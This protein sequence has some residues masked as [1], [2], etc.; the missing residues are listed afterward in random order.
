MLISSL[1]DF[2]SVRWYLNSILP[3]LYFFCFFFCCAGVALEA[4]AATEA[5]V[6]TGGG[7]GAGEVEA[8]EDEVD[9]VL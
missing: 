9:C 1:F 3:S 6:G 2:L 4:V 8:S 5:Q 7:G